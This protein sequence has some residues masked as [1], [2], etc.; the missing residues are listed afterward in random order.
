MAR[1]RPFSAYRYDL[2]RVRAADVL[3]Q[4][5]DKITPAMRERYLAASPYNLVRVILGEKL[6]ND[7]E[8]D[9]VYTRAAEHLQSWIEQGILRADPEPGIYPY[10]QSFRRPG[11]E[12]GGRNDRSTRHG[13]IALGALE[14]Y[15]NRVV[16][17][18]E[19]TLSGPKLDRQALLRATRTHF[20]QIFM[21]Y[22]DPSQKVEAELLARATNPV[23]EADDEYDT[24]HRL[25]RETDAGVIERLQQQLA[26]LP[27]IIADGHHRYETALQWRNEQNGNAPH[28]AA[29]GR[30]HPWDWVMMTF[31]NLDAPGLVVLPT[32]RLVYGLDGWDAAQ[33]W[34][35]LRQCFDVEDTGLRLDPSNAGPIVQK[36][37][38]AERPPLFAAALQGSRSISLLRPKPDLD[39]AALLPELLPEQRRL[40]VVLLHRL[41]LDRSLGVTPEMV[42]G[43]RCL[44]YVKDAGEALQS[45]AAGAAQAAFLLNPIPA[46]Q[47]RDVALAGAVLPQ[48]STDFFPKLLT[49]LTLYRAV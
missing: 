44:R 40:D 2:G 1:I 19:Q 4:P 27:L 42:R 34:A 46:A 25:F 49:G 17:R 39:W 36:L 14:E 3:T 35:K 24:R 9:N 6:E 48:K 12:A 11:A 47:V 31:I 8:R 33:A 22:S 20:G 13:F 28:R 38:R 21:L 45:V 18:H 43:E 16:F 26:P 29:E 32:H 7:S 23:L 15:S 30:G 5:Y 37:A 41:A 10:E